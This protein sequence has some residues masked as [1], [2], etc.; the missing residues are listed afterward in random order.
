MKRS[1]FDFTVD[2][3]SDHEPALDDPQELRGAESVKKLKAYLESV[4]AL[5]VT[6]NKV[7]V[8]AVAEAV[9]IDRQVLYKNPIARQLVAEAVA[10]K[11]LR[12]IVPRENRSEIGF[13]QLDRRF[14]ALQSDIAHGRTRRNERPKFADG[15]EDLM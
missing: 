3:A 11:G 14:A 9:R 1:D 4:D 5:P 10:E 15:I 12:G 6:G 2:I 7:H 13:A 8:S